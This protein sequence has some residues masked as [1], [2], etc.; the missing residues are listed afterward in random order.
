MV[1]CA[2]RQHT[3]H[4]I[5]ITNYPLAIT[6]KIVPIQPKQKLFLVSGKHLL[7]TKLKKYLLSVLNLFRS[8]II[9][10]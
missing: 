10:K 8:F 6:N 1:R 3:L 9:L 2:S 4:L 7:K 5:P